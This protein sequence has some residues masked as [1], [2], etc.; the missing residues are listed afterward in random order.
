MSFQSFKGKKKRLEF[1]AFLLR[2]YVCA[3]HVLSTE[4]LC[5]VK[6]TVT[7]KNHAAADVAIFSYLFSLQM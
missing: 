3:H 6:M 1:G 2:R 5:L 4:H 7:L